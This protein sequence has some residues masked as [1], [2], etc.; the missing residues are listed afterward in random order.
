MSDGQRYR[1]SQGGSFGLTRAPYG[2]VCDRDLMGCLEA[3]VHP[4]TAD[5]NLRTGQRGGDSSPRLDRLLA[6]LQV[7][8]AV[9]QTHR[10][11]RLPQSL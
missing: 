9:G 2:A 4:V 11:L 5:T 8:M 10:L 7:G 1:L 3:L 6:H